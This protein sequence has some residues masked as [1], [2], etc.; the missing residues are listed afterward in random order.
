MNTEQQN[1]IAKIKEITKRIISNIEIQDAYSFFKKYCD[2]LTLMLMSDSLYI[3]S[4]HDVV[5]I[6]YYFEDKDLDLYVRLTSDYAEELYELIESLV[7]Y[8]DE[9]IKDIQNLKK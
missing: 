5:N 1:D 2:N 3:S 8:Q 4:E 9:I 6:I 7:K